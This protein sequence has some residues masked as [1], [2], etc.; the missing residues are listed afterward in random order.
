MLD[1]LD[2]H[3]THLTAEEKESVK[4][5]VPGTGL[6]RLAYEVV[7]RGYS[8]QGYEFSHYMLLSSYFILN[9]TEQINQHTIYPYIHSFSNMRSSETLFKEIKIPDILPSDIP[10]GPSFSLVAGDFEEIYGILNEGDEREPQQGKWDAVLTCFF[11]DTA[12][13]IVNY[14][15]IIYDLLKPE[16]IW[17]NLGPLLWHWENVGPGAGT[18]DISIELNLDEIRRLAHKIGFEIGNEQTI[19]TT[20]TGISDSMLGYVYHTAFWTATKKAN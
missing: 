14:L 7:K 4:V 15:Q 16:G 1:A 18:S 6:G 10:R 5:L 8:C 11:I 9:R 20:Y 13:N 2:M 3:F 12:K 17:I 19:V